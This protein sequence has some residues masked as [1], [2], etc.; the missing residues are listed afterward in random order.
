MQK[1]V[2]FVYEKFVVIKNLFFDELKVRILMEKYL[3][4]QHIN[5]VKCLTSQVKLE[6]HL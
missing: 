6:T 3:L 4:G 5:R 1:T 2:N